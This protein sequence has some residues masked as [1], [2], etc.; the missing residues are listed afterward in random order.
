MN[1]M[2]TRTPVTPAPHRVDLTS[3]PGALIVGGA[4]VSIGVARSLGRQGVPVWLLANHPLPTYSRYVER[5]FP[6]PGADHADGLSS[7]IDLAKQHKLHG[8]V[9]IATGDEDMRM[10]AQNHALL[11]QYFRVATPD[12]DTIQWA[13]DKRLTYRRAASL[14]IDFPASFHPRSLDEIARLDCR[15]PVI[16]KPAFR[17]GADEFTQAKAWKA[18]D[19]AQLLALYQRAAALIGG[20]AIIVQEW[21]P[22]TGE[23]QYS[24]AGLWQ[25]GEPVVSLVARRRRQHPIDFGRSS[26][27]VETIEQSEV[28]ELAGRF[29]KSLNYTGVVEV[30]FKHDRRDGHYKLLDV[31][32]RFWTWNGLGALAGVDFPYLAW[33][34]ALGK[35]VSP[36]RARPGVAWMHAS[37]DVIAAYEEISN[38]TLTARD[39]LLSFRKSLAFANFAFDDPVPAMVELPVAA[40]NRFARGPLGV[41]R[42]TLV[43]KIAHKFGMAARRVAK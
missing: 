13:Y 5:S 19:R 26:T 24:Y 3:A 34:Q 37:R 38:D 28:E 1:F 10:I 33:R 25:R 16:L 30:E 8:W 27:Y 21:I 22:G 6:W 12:W 43:Q 20:E 42:H 39:Y 18:D 29:L 2:P 35:T 31:N 11:S 14:G 41:Q 40:W 9:L 4:H 7:I 15:F 23:T 17:K 36:G 32:G